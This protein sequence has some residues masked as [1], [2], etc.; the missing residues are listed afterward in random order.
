MTTHE[1]QVK[2]A[3]IASK[4]QKKLMSY[5]RRLKWGERRQII[6]MRFGSIG[7]LE[8]TDKSYAQVASRLVIRLRTV[9]SVCRAYLGRGGSLP[10]TI[11]QPKIYKLTACQRAWATST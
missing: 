10:Q 1:K 4:K 3:K 6:L 2:R 11:E 7:S 9:I 8:T 5:R